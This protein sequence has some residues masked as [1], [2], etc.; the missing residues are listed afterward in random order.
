MLLHST[1]DSFKFL[2]YSFSN[3]FTFNYLISLHAA[4]N[5]GVVGYHAVR[6]AASL[7]AGGRFKEARIT[8]LLT[9]RMM[10]RTRLA[11]AILHNHR[12]KQ[13]VEGRYYDNLY[14]Q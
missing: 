8:A 13:L 4:I 14:T 3:T 2:H 12:N 1:V 11:T 5:I 10:K 9:E 7:A 6:S